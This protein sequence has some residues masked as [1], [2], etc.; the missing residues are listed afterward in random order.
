MSKEGQMGVIP[1]SDHKRKVLDNEQGARRLTINIA[2]DD[3]TKRYVMNA[4]RGLERQ[5]A[6]LRLMP[7]AEILIV[8]DAFGG[9]GPIAWQGLDYRHQ[10]GLAELF[11]LYVDPRY[12][13]YRLSAVLQHIASEYLKS[14]NLQSAL[15][16]MDAIG[17]RSLLEWRL[18]HGFWKKLDPEQLTS[19]TIGLC[20]HCE[21]YDRTCSAQAYLMFDLESFRQQAEQSLGT[22]RPLSFPVRVRIKDGQFAYVPGNAV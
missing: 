5:T 1:N 16:R 15:I 9:E 8:S 21:L 10:P 18:A 6:N 11:S 2:S 20:R 12:R 7:T 4:L 3:A 14:K 13:G 17:T 22:L 19:Q